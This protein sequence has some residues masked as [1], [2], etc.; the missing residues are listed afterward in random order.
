VPWLA[1]PVVIH[2][3][4]RLDLES[5]Q[6]FRALPS[7]K[8]GIGMTKTTICGLY[9]R[10]SSRNQL[11]PEYNSLETQKERLEAYCKAQDYGIYRVYEDGAY[12]GDSLDRP[13]LKQ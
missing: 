6:N 4:D 9:T 13:A 10:V 7:Q 11:E 8:R 3:Y 1:V 5:P 2:I 12:S